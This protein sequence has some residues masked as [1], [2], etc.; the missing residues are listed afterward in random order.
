L[1]FEKWP[2]DD[3]IKDPAV[4]AKWQA[5]IDMAYKSYLDSLS[6][7]DEITD[8]AVATEDVVAAEE[9]AAT[10]ADITGAPENTYALVETMPKGWEDPFDYIVRNTPEPERSRML[11]DWKLEERC[12]DRSW[13]AVEDDDQ[14]DLSGARY[15]DC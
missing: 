3:A 15:I 2:M 14:E 11:L 5:D 4:E 6:S 9:A 10:E 8:N 12:R 7:P 13:W 1:L